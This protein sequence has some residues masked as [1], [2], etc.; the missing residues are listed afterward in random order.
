MDSCLSA[1]A[2]KC[3]WKA[4]S[5]HR[6]YRKARQPF[7]DLW[8]LACQGFPLV[9]LQ[10]YSKLHWLSSWKNRYWWLN[11]V[12]VVRWSFA[13]RV[14][15]YYDNTERMTESHSV[16]EPATRS[17]RLCLRLLH[18]I[19]SQIWCRQGWKIGTNGE[20]QHMNPGKETR[21]AALGHL[22]R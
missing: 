3:K 4:K 1:G 21:C 17:V 11:N 15:K 5:D 14:N 2:L 8:S 10:H 20:K 12:L 7:T 22:S 13:L 16:F 9:H 18:W 6:F 19:V